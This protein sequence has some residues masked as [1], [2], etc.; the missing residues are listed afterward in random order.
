VARPS[1]NDVASAATDSTGSIGP[2]SAP[3]DDRVSP[4]V[5]L[6][7]AEQAD[8][9][10]TARTAAVQPPPAAAATPRAAVTRAVAVQTGDNE[11]TIAVKRVSG[12]PASA[13]LTVANKTSAAP[14]A[15][16]ARVDD[17]WLRA[18]VLA[19]SVDRFLCIT[20]LGARDFRS[21]A[22]LIGK[23]ASSVMMT[24]SADPQLGLAQDHFSGSA[25]V[26]VS[27]VTYPMRSA[28]LQ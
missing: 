12:R 8:R 27:T 26:F 7:Y 18:I 10:A 20:A 14:L 23:P 19:P 11:M 9:E 4:D 24:F 3:P 16:G 21:L 15:A 2:F 17:P 22:A 25:I 5:A 1:R 6:A 13:I 28:S